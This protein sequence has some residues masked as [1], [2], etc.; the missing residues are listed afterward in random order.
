[1]QGD[2]ASQAERDTDSLLRFAV[3]PYQFCVPAVQVQAIIIPPR[4]TV[5]PMSHV[6]VA[7]I[8]MYQGEVVSCIDMRRRFS[9]SPRPAGNAG[10]L[11]LGRVNG[12]LYAFWVDEVSDIVSSDTM[13]WSALPGRHRYVFNGCFLKDEDIILSTS[14]EQLFNCGRLDVNSFLQDLVTGEVDE[15]LRKQASN[16]AAGQKVNKQHANDQHN[17]DQSIDEQP[18]DD[19]QDSTTVQLNDAFNRVSS[20]ARDSKPAAQDSLQTSAVD[21]SSADISADVSDGTA[22]IASDETD[23]HPDVS[24]GAGSSAEMD[25]SSEDRAGLQSGPGAA[26]R[27]TGDGNTASPS[28]N[29][30]ANISGTSAGASSAVDQTGTRTDHDKSAVFDHVSDES[31]PASA[32]SSKDLNASKTASPGSSSLPSTGGS[33]QP[34]KYSSDRRDSG[35]QTPGFGRSVSMTKAATTPPDNPD[36][37]DHEARESGTAHSRQSGVQT[38]FKTDTDQNALEKSRT[39]TINRR[40]TGGTSE[41]TNSS[42]GVRQTTSLSP[43]GLQTVH[44][45]AGP[46]LSRIPLRYWQAVSLFQYQVD[47]HQ[48]DVRPGNADHPLRYAGFPVGVAFPTAAVAAPP[49]SPA[50]TIALLIDQGRVPWLRDLMVALFQNADRHWNRS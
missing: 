49:A 9:L 14:M 43:S 12:T 37:P 3:L 32:F 5:L 50:A 19:Q 2:N 4:L 20:L 27:R 40:Q 17:D 36:R 10:Q 21:A 45:V 28:S 38:A 23:L 48:P 29:V 26:A 8:F 33:S 13:T 1:M 34:G 47:Y 25:V 46:A 42:A 30:F 18:A 35:R 44:S 41:A 16:L 22:A 31:N 7:G 6:D 15:R 11:L 39:T 24:E